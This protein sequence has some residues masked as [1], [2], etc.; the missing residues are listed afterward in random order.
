M[1]Q[2]TFYKIKYEVTTKIFLL[3]EIDPTVDDAGHTWLEGNTHQ[4]QGCRGP[5]TSIGKVKN[6]HVIVMI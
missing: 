1:D 2:T 3:N 4:N 5:N 6:T